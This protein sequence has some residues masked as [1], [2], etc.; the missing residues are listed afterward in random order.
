MPRD[1]QNREHS[2]RPTWTVPLLVPAILAIAALTAA[3]G[4]GSGSD[5]PSG[6]AI[7]PLGGPVPTISDT[8]FEG[9]DMELKERTGRDP[10]LN[11]ARLGRVEVVDLGPFSRT[12]FYFFER[13]PDYR[14][15]YVDEP[16]ACGSGLRVDVQGEAFLK[17]TFM[18]STAHNEATGEP[19]VTIADDLMEQIPAV[20]DIQ[21]SCDAEAELT[22]VLGLAQRADFRVGFTT[23]P[24]RYESILIDIEN[25]GG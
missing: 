22:Y 5:T 1:H 13:I 2:T 9:G 12:V 3:C 10:E 25:S 15:Q 8:S 23:L 11:I 14:V 7:D 17:V 20:V 24:I 16:I 18:P 21:Q 6:T 4:D 19:W